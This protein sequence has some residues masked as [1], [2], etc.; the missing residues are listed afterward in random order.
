MLGGPTGSV[1]D[2]VVTAYRAAPTSRPRLLSAWREKAF[3]RFLSL[4]FPTTGHE[5]WKYT[6]VSPLA[7]MAFSLPPFQRVTIA[8][9]IKGPKL[10]FVNG[11]FQ[12]N[13]SDLEELPEGVL[14]KSIREVLEAGDSS[15]KSLIEKLTPIACPLRGFNATCL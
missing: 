3:Q 13:L 14:V 9:A 6:N 15:L 2:S 1:N 10:V 5:E 11:W 12:E 8:T 7:Q 4:G